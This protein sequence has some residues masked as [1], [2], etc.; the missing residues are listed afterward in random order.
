ML[1]VSAFASSII[2]NIPFVA[3]MIPL[4]KAIGCSAGPDFNILPLWW[5]LSLGACLGGN[6]SLVGAS[7][8]LVVAGIAEKS[9]YK[10]GFVSFIKIGLPIMVLSIIISTIYVYLRYLM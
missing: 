4:I 8:N 9:N 7:A 6:G 1:W 10:I 5:A 2:D 3:T